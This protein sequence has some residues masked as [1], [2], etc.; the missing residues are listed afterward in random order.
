MGTRLFYVTRQWEL[1]S[2]LISIRQFTW[3]PEKLGTIRSRNSVSVLGD[4]FDLKF[5][6]LF[7]ATSD[8]GSD[9]KRLCDVLLPGLWE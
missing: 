7:S 6:N 9:V 5:S 4:E 2:R 8:A 3:D 1:R